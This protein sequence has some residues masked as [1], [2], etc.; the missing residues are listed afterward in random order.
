MSTLG[1]RLQMARAAAQLSQKA[2]AMA[3]GVDQTTIARIEG[4]SRSSL[5]RLVE[6]AKVLK[7][8]PEWLS[9]GS[10]EMQAQDLIDAPVLAFIP[11][12]DSP[13]SAG[14]GVETTEP[15]PV[16]HLAFLTEWIRSEGWREKDLELYPI[17]GDSM[18][19]FAEDGDMALVNKAERE[20]R[21][22]DPRK[23]VF[24]VQYGRETFI[25]HLSY[26]HR[27][28]MVLTSFNLDKSRHPDKIIRGDELDMV[29]IDG[30]VVWRGGKT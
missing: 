23:C 20:L 9:S 12:Y 10:G 7:V 2:V 21:F 25:K 4:G 22:R 30:R 26:N 14:D 19:G 27:D 28:E 5:R 3:A 11:F 1:Q 13:M 29:R 18:T 24:R 8:R 17:R 6:V 15:E 16:K